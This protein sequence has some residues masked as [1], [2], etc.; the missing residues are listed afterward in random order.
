ML[1]WPYLND[2]C[3]VSPIKN[4]AQP[5]G[6]SVPHSRPYYSS[7]DSNKITLTATKSENTM[8]VQISDSI[9]NLCW[10]TCQSK[11]CHDLQSCE[12]GTFSQGSMQCCASSLCIINILHWGGILAYSS[13]HRCFCWLRVTDVHLYKALLGSHCSISVELRFWLG[14]CSHSLILFFSFSAFPFVDLLDCF[15]TLSCC[16]SQF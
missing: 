6:W 13:L 5:S 11:S 14:H 4:G 16:I 10:D 9:D 2:R 7:N 8:Q 15:G 1:L 12:K 3:E